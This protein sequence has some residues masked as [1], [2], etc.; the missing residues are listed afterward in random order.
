MVVSGAVL[1]GPVD[2]DALQY[3]IK[4]PGV[5]FPGISLS[6]FRNVSPQPPAELRLRDELREQKRQT[7]RVGGIFEDQAVLGMGDDLGDTRLP[8]YHN[9]KAAGHGLKR[10]HREGILQR[11]AHVGI[12]R[13]V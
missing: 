3:P 4:L 6:S 7:I 9:R 5:R 1:W 12:S 11:G 2:Q 13:R 8:A 10:R